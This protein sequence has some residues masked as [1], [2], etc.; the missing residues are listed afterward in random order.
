MT[1]FQQHGGYKYIPYIDTYVHTLTYIHTYKNI[2][3]NQMQKGSVSKEQNL[4]LKHKGKTEE[5][6][7]QFCFDVNKINFATLNFCVQGDSI[8]ARRVV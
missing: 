5:F 7:F 4:F 1:H 2:C 6:S 8:H 3:P